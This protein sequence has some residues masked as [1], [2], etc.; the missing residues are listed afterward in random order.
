[1]GLTQVPGEPPGTEGWCSEHVRCRHRPLL[2]FLLEARAGGAA[3]GHGHQLQPAGQDP[4]E[5]PD[6]ACSGDW[7]GAWRASPPQR[8]GGPH[9]LCGGVGM[10][11]PCRG[12]APPLP[13]PPAVAPCQPRTHLCREEPFW[14]RLRESPLSGVSLQDLSRVAVCPVDVT[15]GE[16]GP[17]A[18]GG[19]PLLA[20]GWGRGPRG[21]H[22][23]GAATRASVGWESADFPSKLGK[24]GCVWAD[25]S[26]AVIC[27]HLCPQG[28]GKAGGGRVSG[29]APG[30]WRPR[31]AQGPRLALLCFPPPASSFIRG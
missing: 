3:G 10:A 23:V 17:E 31:A 16:H 26:A 5:P 24:W 13:S 20:P 14:R 30:R 25:G 27:R 29:A 2:G 8:A 12:L 9:R 21:S 7:A 1:M 4:P 6:L 19:L 22:A 15:S 18:G 11:A 28:T